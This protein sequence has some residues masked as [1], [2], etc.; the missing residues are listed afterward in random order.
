MSAMKNPRNCCGV[1]SCA[2][3]VCLVGCNDFCFQLPAF[4]KCA[5]KSFLYLLN[6]M[7]FTSTPGSTLTGIGLFP[8]LVIIWSVVWN[9]VCPSD[10]TSV[11]NLPSWLGCVLEIM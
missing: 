5:G 9:D 4:V 1:I 6:G 11:S 3:R 10:A 8:C 7:V 2:V